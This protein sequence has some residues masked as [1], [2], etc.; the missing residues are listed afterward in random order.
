MRC[1][2][3]CRKSVGALKKIAAPASSISA[4]APT[5]SCSSLFNQSESG[6]QRGEHHKKYVEVDEET[7]GLVVAARQSHRRLHGL[8]TRNDEW[9]PEREREQG[10]QQL[11]RTHSSDYRRKQAAER[12][13]ADRR[14]KNRDPEVAGE[15][16][17]EEQRKRREHDDFAK[18]QEHR[19]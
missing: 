17:A 19:G 13:H 2:G 5:G 10:Q 4:T 15:G 3:P 16:C 1:T 12:R 7:N 8:A 9:N 6:R 11:S 14:E 18:N